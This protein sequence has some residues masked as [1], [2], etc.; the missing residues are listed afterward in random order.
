MKG[1]EYVGRG[2][3]GYVFEVRGKIVYHKVY[4]LALYEAIF[5]YITEE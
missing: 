3:S 2:A 4:L 5:T 1:F